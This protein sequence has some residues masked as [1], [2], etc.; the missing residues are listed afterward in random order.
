MVIKSEQWPAPG[1]SRRWLYVWVGVLLALVS[2][3]SGTPHN[4]VST[5]GGHEEG[6]RL[7]RAPEAE[8]VRALTNEIRMLSARVSPAEAADCAARSI[9]YSELMR[10]TYGV[11]EPIELNNIMINVGLK[12]R[13]LCYQMA[14]DLQAEL[15]AQK[16][17]TLS[18]QRATAHWHDVIDE[19][20]CVVVTGVGQAFEKGL[21]LDPWRNAGVLRW[22][23][24]ARDHYPW[25]ARN[26]G[27]DKAGAVAT[28]R[29]VGGD[30]GVASG[31]G[32]APRKRGG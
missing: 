19:H 16:Y 18:F 3:C 11:K 32:D 30:A 21:V 25:V 20:N 1:L 8:R 22:A 10:D 9:R 26:P 15:K 13:G 23:R 27:V 14:D 2:G 17:R 24:V 5:L 4:T 31:N 12:K 28:T 7:D 29:P 6:A